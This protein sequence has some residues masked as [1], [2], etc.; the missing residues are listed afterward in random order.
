MSWLFSQA[1]V[2]EYLEATY[3]GGEQS[4]QWS[5]TAT[6]QAYC[7]PDKMTN[8]SRLSRFGMT[9]APLTDDRGAELLTWFREG[10]LA[11]TSASQE[12]EPELTESVPVFGLKCLGLLARFD[13]DSCSW[14]TPQ[15]SLLGGGS[16][17]LQTLPRW[18]IAADGELW[19][20]AMSER[21][22]GEN[23][24]G[25]W[26]TPSA[27]EDAAGTPNGKMQKMLGNDPRIRGTTPEEWARG[28]LN[29]TWVE[30]LMGW[31]LGWTDLKPLEMDRFQQWQQQHLNYSANPKLR[32]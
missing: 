29:P 1:L 17:S 30:W 23:E 25:F 14:K 21:P 15:L 13:R 16:E 22:I 28:T 26:L 31:P 24:S 27:N 32:Q 12:K 9:F 11:R 19:E 2:A 10:F 3:L 8:V 4:A 18:G 5:E 7:S 6:P 20:L